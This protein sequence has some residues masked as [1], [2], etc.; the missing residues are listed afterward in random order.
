MPIVYISGFG[1][2][3]QTDQTTTGNVIGFLNKP[4]TS[5]LLIKTVE[6]HMPRLSGEPE[7]IEIE[8]GPGPGEVVNDAEPTAA[9]QEETVSQES[10]TS[11]EVPTQAPDLWN[12][13]ASTW[14]HPA[15]VAPI[16]AAEFPNESFTGGMYFCGD[17]GF[18]S[19]NRAL[20]TIAKERLTG[21]LRLFWEKDPVELFVQNGQIVLATTRN[22]ELYC[23]DAPI[24]LVN[25]ETDRIAEARSQ[26]SVNGCPLFLALVEEEKAP[27]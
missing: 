10:I 11:A 18:F 23:P 9:L 24:T 25:V 3:L 5:D 12:E 2:D 17:T 7:P 22:P 19:L 16:D 21:S 6:T 15:A 1:A 13:T 27:T 4:F 8:N 26:Q 14:S 20:Q